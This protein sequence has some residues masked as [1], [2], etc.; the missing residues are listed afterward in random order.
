MIRKLEKI[1]EGDILKISEYNRF[2]R[3]QTKEVVR[4]FSNN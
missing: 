2:K 4:T 1:M 3:V